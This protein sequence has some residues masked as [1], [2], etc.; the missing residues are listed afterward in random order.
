MSV[1]EVEVA[2]T[3]NPSALRSFV[4]RRNS[5]PN[6]T[7]WEAICAT[8]AEPEL[9]LPVSIDSGFGNI[10]IHFFGAGLGHSNP[11]NHALVEA[12]NIRSFKGRTVSC[13]YSIGAGKTL[14]IDHSPNYLAMLEEKEVR[15]DPDVDDDFD[16]EIADMVRSIAR[17]CENAHLEMHL[18]FEGRPFYFRFD[19]ERGLEDIDV[20]QEWKHLDYVEA[21]ARGSVNV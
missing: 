20:I 7:V 15:M 11:I 18:K 17:S 13:I 4:P 6:C 3:P 9:F 16:I 2:D 1:R 19:V 5:D 8:L 12:D 10:P 21:M 14:P